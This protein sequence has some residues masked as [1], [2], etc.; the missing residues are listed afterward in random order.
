MPF[1]C[2]EIPPTS[3]GP[4][5]TL[6]SVAARTAR[7]AP[8]VATRGLR[9]MR[10]VPSRARL[11][12]PWY[13]A[14]ARPIPQGPRLVL[15]EGT[16]R[17]TR[18]TEDVPGPGPATSLRE[19]SRP[20]RRSVAAAST[21]RP[22]SG[23]PAPRGTVGSSRDGSGGKPSVGWRSREPR[24]RT[25][26]PEGGQLPALGRD[27]ASCRPGRCS[28]LGAGRRTGPSPRSSGRGT[29]SGNGEN[30]T[31]T[32]GRGGPARTQRTVG[33]TGRPLAGEPRP[34]TKPP[35]A[36]GRGRSGRSGP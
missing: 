1:P 34:R 5:L 23:I 2:E 11:F 30:S 29:S 35:K 17:E 10:A 21:H 14:R 26:F 12:T 6:T 9:G 33:R 18:S 22:R 20:P 15:D 25:R 16:D 27:D 24:P 19:G 31:A 28:D 7:T 32:S 8:N 36:R 13:A 3:P 4:T